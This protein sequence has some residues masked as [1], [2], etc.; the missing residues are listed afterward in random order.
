M[1]RSCPLTPLHPLGHLASLVLPHSLVFLVTSAPPARGVPGPH[2]CLPIPSSLPPR[3]AGPCSPSLPHLPF[4][5]RALSCTLSPCRALHCSA[6]PWALGPWLSRSLVS[7]VPNSAPVSSF[8]CGVSL[9]LSLSPSLLPSPPF[10]SPPFFPPS[11]SLPPPPPSGCSVSL[12]LFPAFGSFY[13]LKGEARHPRDPLC[14]P[15]REAAPLPAP[16][17]SLR[18][19]V[20]AAVP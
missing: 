15:N 20:R 11:L 4:G 16:R 7:L 10:L 18:R 17:S 14:S 6:W 2:I 3:L 9:S 1:G 12:C 13:H 19:S 5:S 8:P